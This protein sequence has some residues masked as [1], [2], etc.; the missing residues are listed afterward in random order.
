MENKALTLITIITE[1]ALESLLIKDILKLGAKGYTITDV[2]GSGSRG[3]RN[4]GW[5]AS[6]NIRIEIVC[7]NTVSEA[8]AKH[9]QKTYYENYAMIIYT[10]EVNVLR[11][12]KF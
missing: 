5:D 1:T 3:N 6:A 8:I 2:R 7:T 12:E 9:L 4:A 11:P 10:S